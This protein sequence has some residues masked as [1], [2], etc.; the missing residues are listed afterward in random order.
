MLF[1]QLVIDKKDD[2][3]KIE[4][5][6]IDMSDSQFAAFKTVITSRSN[7]LITGSAGTGKS[8][9]IKKIEEKL[10]E[11]KKN[12]IIT[13]TSGV[14]ASNIDAITLHSFG[15][16]GLGNNDH[17]TSLDYA[18]NVLK[19]KT[20][21]KRYKETDVLIIDEIS[22]V[23]G[24]FLFLLGKI[25]Q[26]IRRNA[27]PFGGIQLV[28]L[29][30]FLQLPSRCERQF[31]EHPHFKFF[32]DVVCLLNTSFRQTDPVF[33]SLLNCVR[34][35]K[36]NDSVKQQ[37]KQIFSDTHNHRALGKDFIGLKLYSK[38]KDVEES[39]RRDDST[40]E[41]EAKTLDISF[42]MSAISTKTIQTKGKKELD[43]FSNTEK[44]VTITKIL[45]DSDEYKKRF[46]N[47]KP[48]KNNKR[49]KKKEII[50]KE[51]TYKL[52]ESQTAY[53]TTLIS[54]LH[55]ANV[56]IHK[57]D[58][59][60]LKEATMFLKDHSITLPHQLKIGTRVML[61]FNISTTN[62]L[63]N[64]ARGI[65]VNFIKSETP[66]KLSLLKE[67]LKEESKDIDNEELEM[68]LVQQL[69]NIINDESSS[70]GEYIYPVVQF[71]NELTCVVPSV[72]FR[73]KLDGGLRTLDEDCYINWCLCVEHIP[74][75]QASAMTVH[76]AQGLTLRDG[77]A[78]QMRGIFERGQFYV[79][80]SR[81]KTSTSLQLMDFKPD[82]IK[83]D[84]KAVAFYDTL[85]KKTEEFG[86]V[87]SMSELFS[88]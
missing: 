36:I 75:I 16:I 85:L 13:A 74:L 15:G 41:T 50:K 20:I 24:D 6:N 64:G 48:V 34:V 84:E 7:I 28:L 39:N 53:L 25:A 81:V 2:D 55:G 30:D 46:S 86:Y 31:Y 45:P 70:S 40:N 26:H 65:V 87:V 77:A 69:T 76:K 66:I 44:M 19:N 82:V 57:Q 33:L 29:G 83:A 88:K 5:T 61:R 12:V 72:E 17:F 43:I 35:G 51:T 9:L 73:H 68:L 54:K 8:F 58:I 3:D 63:V 67:K 27:L 52:S 79:A 56:Y 18:N 37:L 38:N 23:D 14:A 49:D 11:L 78:V 22:M 32:I 21:A 4:L 80:M 42:F 62:G 60:A 1:E 59:E 10:I 47:F 71:D